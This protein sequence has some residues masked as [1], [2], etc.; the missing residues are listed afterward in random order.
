LQLLHLLLQLLHLLLHLLHLL[1]HLLHL[2]LHLLL[3]LL[4]LLLQLLQLIWLSSTCSGWVTYAQMCCEDKT[5]QRVLKGT[6]QPQ[7][8]QRLQQQLQ[9]LQQQVQH[10]SAACA[11]VLGAACLRA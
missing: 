10:G 1:L 9:Q 6:L 3:Q 11:C 2:L 7:Q 8:L 4:H 5:L